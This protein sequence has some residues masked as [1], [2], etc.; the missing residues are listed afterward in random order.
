MYDLNRFLT[1]LKLT[2][3]IC[4][5]CPDISLEHYYS[6]TDGGIWCRACMKAVNDG[7]P[8]EVGPCTSNYFLARH[9]YDPTH[10]NYSMG[11][12]NGVPNECW[13]KLP[14]NSDAHKEPFIK[15]A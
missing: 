2:N 7:D 11:G 8:R 5:V 1:S 4:I 9:K 6:D 12:R 14:E 15:V 13:C 10:P 3:A